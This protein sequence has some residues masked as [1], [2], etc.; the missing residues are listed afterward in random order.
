MG[1]SVPEMPRTFRLR[2]LFILF[3]WYSFAMSTIFQSFFTSFLVSPGYDSGI[4]SL[5]DLRH[6]GLKYGSDSGIDEF[7]HE[8]GYVEHET[9]N[10]DRFVPSDLEKCMERVFT[11]RD[12]TTVA[13][14][15]LAQYVATRIGKTSD[16]NSLC[17]L[18]ENIFSSNVVLMLPRGHPVIER[19]NDVIRHSFEAGLGDKYWSDLQFNLTLQNTRK[20]EESDCQTCSEMYFVFTLTHLGVAFL[21]LG[22]GYLLSVAVFVVELICKWI[23]NRRTVIFN[24]HDTAPFPFLR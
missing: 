9:L 4:S 7:L 19:F 1:V 10:L 18:D 14:S 2:T 21:V 20:S 24:M 11:E 13:P 22:F 6:S 5:D 15:F 16:E 23:S 12:T 3:V 17:S 8:V